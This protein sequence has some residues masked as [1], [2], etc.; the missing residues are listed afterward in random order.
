MVGTWQIIRLNRCLLWGYF[1]GGWNWYLHTNF[2]PVGLHTHKYKPACT[3]THT[4]TSTHTHTHWTFQLYQDSLLV[5]FCFYRRQPLSLYQVSPLGNGIATLSSLAI[6][7][8]RMEAVYLCLPGPVED[9]E[10]GGPLL[11]PAPPLPL[12]FYPHLRDKDIIHH[13]SAH[14]SVSC[15]QDTVT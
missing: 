9:A 6:W 8:V 5:L 3:R 12:C 7:A 14:P 4:H 11:P 10:Q 13:P 2:M 15:K 1:K